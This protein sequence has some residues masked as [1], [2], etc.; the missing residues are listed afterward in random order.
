MHNN[1]NNNKQIVMNC[2]PGIQ[3]RHTR[4]YLSDSFYVFKCFMHAAN[5]NATFLL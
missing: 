4:I 5:Y 2:I 3:G 1:L